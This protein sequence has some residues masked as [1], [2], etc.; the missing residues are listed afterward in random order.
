VRLLGFPFPVIIACN[1]H[2]IA[3][4]ALLLLSTDYRIGAIGN[5]KIGLDEVAIGL[6]LSYFGVEL[7]IFRLSAP[8]LNRSTA[9]A[10]IYTPQGAVE[11]GF[12]DM[13]VPEKK[14]MATTIPT[15]QTLPN[16]I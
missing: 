16:W 4:A 13:I 1:G 8:Y 6:P 11:A 2:C 3:L 15:A 5:Y 9:N 14:L 12:L 7:A 10:E